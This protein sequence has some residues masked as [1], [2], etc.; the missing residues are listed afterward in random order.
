MLADVAFA[1]SAEQGIDDGMDHHIAVAVSDRAD[2]VG[3]DDSA[4]DQ[5]AAVFEAVNVVAATDAALNEPIM[6]PNES[7]TTRGCF[8]R[9]DTCVA[10]VSSPCSIHNIPCT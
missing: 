3:D 10:L 1:R 7:A 5:F 6:A 9:G 4:E 2:V 8:C